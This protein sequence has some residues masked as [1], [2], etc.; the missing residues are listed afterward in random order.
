MM[1]MSLMGAMIVLGLV[2]SQLVHAKNPSADRVK[3]VVRKNHGFFH[4]LQNAKFIGV[5]EKPIHSQVSS[6]GTTGWIYYNTYFSGSSC[7]D[8]NVATQ[9]GS[10]TG[11]CVILQISDLS[12]VLNS[13]YY[14][15]GGSMYL[16]KYSPAFIVI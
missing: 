14:S 9:G 16:N 1:K 4:T 6:S 7:S 13:A 5:A 8:S 3:N 10:A 12:T 15:C 11:I 2:S